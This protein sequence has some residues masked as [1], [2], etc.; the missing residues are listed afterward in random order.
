MKNTILLF[1][2]IAGLFL[3]CVHQVAVPDYPGSGGITDS[4]GNGGGGSIAD[5]LVC[6]EGDILPI[7]VNS[8]AYAGCHDSKSKQEGYVL[9]SW[10]NIIKRGI[11]PGDPNG[12]NIYEAIVSGN[13]PPGGSL[14]TDQVNLIAKWIKE[15]AKNTTNCNS[16]DTAVFTYKASIAGIMS[17]NCTGC[18]SGSSASGGID[19]STFNG[20]S[21]VALNGRLVGAVTQAPGFIAMPPGGMLSDCDIKQI[22][23]WVAAGAANN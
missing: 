15:G 12:S 10:Q 18:H 9:D 16:C 1:A 8:C 17:T 6:F 22:E 2:A 21:T 5:S 3:S 23:K 4:T 14:T 11:K 13:M 20:V 19:L 7:F